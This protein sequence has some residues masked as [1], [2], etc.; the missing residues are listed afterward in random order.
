MFACIPLLVCISYGVIS[1]DVAFNEWSGYFG[2]RKTITSLRSASQDEQM[3][4]GI[5]LGNL[6]AHELRH[7]FA[8]SMT[9]GGLGHSEHGL[10]MDEANFKDPKI[11]FT[12]SPSIIRELH[13][14]QQIQD[15]YKFKRL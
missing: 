2:E 5:T 8:I 1:L 3:S 14:L 13:K 10:G 6:I 12:D 11:R 15:Q 9:G 4:F 7:Q